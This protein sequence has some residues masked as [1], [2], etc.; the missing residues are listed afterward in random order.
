[1]THLVQARSADDCIR[2][3]QIYVVEHPRRFSTATW[4]SKLWVAPVSLRNEQLAS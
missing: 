4:T 1:M 3:S 2:G